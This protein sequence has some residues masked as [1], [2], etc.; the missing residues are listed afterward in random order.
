MPVDNKRAG[1]RVRG[2]AQS[3][4]T[5]RGQAR[6][7]PN[8][9]IQSQ[10]RT[11]NTDG[12]E[13]QRGQTG[14]SQQGRHRGVADACSRGNRINQ[15]PHPNRPDSHRC[16]LSPR[17]QQPTAQPEKGGVQQNTPHGGRLKA[18]VGKAR[19]G[20]GPKRVEALFVAKHPVEIQ[21]LQ[22]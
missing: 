7:P 15:T 11:G 1:S 6:V 2:A 21:G 12:G 14:D 17:Q 22:T 13:V 18:K 5:V 16:W 10:M 3:F 4:L 8:D 9:P 20:R 19:Q